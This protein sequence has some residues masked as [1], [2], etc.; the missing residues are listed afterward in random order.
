[1]ATCES[2]RIEAKIP[3][4]LDI[5]RIRGGRLANYRDET[6]LSLSLSPHT[7]TASYSPLK[8]FDRDSHAE[9]RFGSEK[10]DRMQNWSAASGEEFGTLGRNSTRGPT[11]N[12]ASFALPCP[13]ASHFSPR[14]LCFLFRGPIL[15]PPRDAGCPLIT[16]YYACTCRFLAHGRQNIILEY[17]TG[18]PIE[19]LCVTLSRWNYHF[20]IIEMWISDKDRIKSSIILASPRWHRS[21]KTSLIS[22]LATNFPLAAHSA[23]S[24]KNYIQNVSHGGARFAQ[25]RERVRAL[26]AC[27]GIFYSLT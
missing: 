17:V 2:V 27:R 11:V 7:Y 5:R 10:L 26:H 18:F 23:I 14:R 12:V 22:S 13:P 19:K 24:H 3:N 4:S 6:S 20:F 9:T 21:R 1:M 16:L 15:I 8:N 25:K